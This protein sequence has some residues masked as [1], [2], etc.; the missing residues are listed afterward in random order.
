MR[1]VPATASWRIPSGGREGRWTYEAPSHHRNHEI[2]NKSL[3][4]IP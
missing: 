4:T 3:H 1:S 2:G